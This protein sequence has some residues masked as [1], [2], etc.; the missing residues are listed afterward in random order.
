MA[1]V[2]LELPRYEMRVDSGAVVLRDGFVVTFFVPRSHREAGPAVRSAVV[3]YLALP[4]VPRALWLLDAE[5]YPQK[6]EEPQVKARLY[7][8]LLGPAPE[9]DLWVADMGNDAPHF[10]V[11]YHGLD[12]QRRANEGWPHATSGVSFTFPTDYLGEAGLLEIFSFA[13]ETARELPFS[14]GLV[15]PAFVQAEGSLESAAFALVRRLSR[16]YRCLEIPALLPDC[17]ECA[18]AAKSAYWG[19]YFGGTLLADLGDETGV[20]PS[21]ALKCGSRHSAPTRCPHI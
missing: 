7:D 9:C 3:R 5:G 2:S 15:S 16:R 18:G 1:L 13:N 4:D 11:R 12:L 20:L 17:F 10:R 14:F 21:R 19:N 8:A 6:H